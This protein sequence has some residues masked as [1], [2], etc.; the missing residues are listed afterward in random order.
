[1][2]SIAIAIFVALFSAALVVV[3][4]NLFGRDKRQKQ[5]T[6]SKSG[7][8]KTAAETTHWRAVKIK[9]GL[10]ACRSVERYANQIFLAKSSP[11]LPLDDCD[12]KKCSC[13]YVHLDDRRSGGDRRAELGELGDFLPFNQTE[14]R[15][16]NGRRD[17][18]LAA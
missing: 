10:I 17:A 1:M 2:N 6:K 9:P 12:E 15:Q 11:R 18:D 5:S 8:Q 14:R 4:T 16:N 7:S 3:V 13:K